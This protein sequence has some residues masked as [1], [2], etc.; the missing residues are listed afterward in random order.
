MYI[1]KERLFETGTK[2]ITY[3]IFST[4]CLYSETNNTRE[5]KI[6]VE[7]SA[8]MFVFLLQSMDKILNSF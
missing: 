5:R 3:M 8:K 6:V 1:Y 4:E 7:R 2:M